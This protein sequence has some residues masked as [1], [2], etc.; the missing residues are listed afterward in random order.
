MGD[1]MEITI[2]VPD[3]YEE[4][5]ANYALEAIKIAIKEAEQAKVQAA[6]DTEVETKIASVTAVDSKG[7]N[8]YVTDTKTN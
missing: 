1:T 2:N 8:L 3:G 4:M 6:V 7:K 5:A